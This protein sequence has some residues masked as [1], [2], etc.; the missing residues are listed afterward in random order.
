MPNVPGTLDY[1]MAPQRRGGSYW[2]ASAG[3][4]A[5]GPYVTPMFMCACGH[6]GAAA[7]PV[8]AASASLAC[9]GWS[10][11]G[12]RPPWRA[13]QMAAAVFALLQLLK[14]LGD[15]LWFGHN[16]LW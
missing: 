11:S 14:N 10:M 8:T 2:W 16:P 4:L 12:A 7:L 15:V 3:S 6:L 13:V 5:I 9:V 1:A